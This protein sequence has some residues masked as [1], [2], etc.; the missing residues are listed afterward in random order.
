MLALMSKKQQAYTEQDLVVAER[1]AAQI[2]GAIANARLFT[3]QRRVEEALRDNEEGY[4]A[5]TESAT[6]AIISANSAGN[7]I[8]WNA[9]ARR[10][11][12]FE[13]EKVLGRPIHQIMPHRYRQTH[14]AGLRRVVTS[15]SSSVIGSIVEMEGLRKDGTEF[16]IETALSTWHAG[17]KR[18]FTAIVRDVME[19]KQAEAKVQELAIFPQ[20]NPAPVLRFDS[21]G[22]IVAANPTAVAV[23]GARVNEALS[24]ETVL[25]VMADINVDELVRLG[26]QV[27][28]ETTIGQRH[29]QFVVLG[30]AEILPSERSCRRSYS[31]PRRWKWWAGWR[32]ASPTTSTTCSRASWASPRYRRKNSLRTTR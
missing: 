26:L 20:L 30:M 13:L 22:V 15:G 32:A 17:G 14:D 27:T 2:S 31:S 1:V 18:F 23:L 12:G 9:S 21:L 19:R 16:P 3:K 24:L 11:F 25:P 7:I 5:V 29:F 28:R 10:T 8:Y 4:R 6:D